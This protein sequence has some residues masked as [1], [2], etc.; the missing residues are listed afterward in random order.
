MRCLALMNQKGGVGKTTTTVNLAAGLALS[1]RR[2]LLVDLDPQAHATLHL[3]ESPSTLQDSVY[4]VLLDPDLALDGPLITSR[5]RLDLLPAETDLA[6]IEQDLG[7]EPDRQH[8]LRRVLDGARDRYDA[9]LIDCPPSLGL[10]TLSGLAAADQVLIPMQAHFLALEGVSKLLETVGLVR[11][12]LN[13]SLRVAGVVLCMHEQQTTLAQEV[14]EELRTFFDSA[15]GTDK[16]WSDARVFEPAIRRNIKLAESPSFGKTIFEYAPEAAGAADY[17]Q[18]TRVIGERVFPTES[19]RSPPEVVVRPHA[20]A[21][22]FQVADP[23]PRPAAQPE[24]RPEAG[25]RDAGSRA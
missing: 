13:P 20:A 8:R 4:D 12:S 22:P 24:A 18:L 6:G 19:D 5:E 14:V 23:D 21:E 7:G 3:G 16:P 9:V 10:L 15:R 17:E 2:V 25:A 1:G 11:G